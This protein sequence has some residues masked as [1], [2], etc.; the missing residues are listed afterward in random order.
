VGTK[1]DSDG[2]SEACHA[3]LFEISQGRSRNMNLGE[4][5]GECMTRAFCVGRVHVHHDDYK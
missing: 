3:A 2:A 5:Y 4:M 1:S